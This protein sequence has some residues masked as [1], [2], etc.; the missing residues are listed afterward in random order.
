MDH[1]IDV[2]RAAADGR[3]TAD[4]LCSLILQQRVHIDDYFDPDTVWAGDPMWL[5][6][7]TGLQAAV[8]AIDSAYPPSSDGDIDTVAL[9]RARR[10]LDALERGDHQAANTHC[11]EILHRL[12]GSE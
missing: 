3:K 4:E 6:F 8:H 12:K 9:L 1:R 11:N 2:A 7:G 5:C 10:L